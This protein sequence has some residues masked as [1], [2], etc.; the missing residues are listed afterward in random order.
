MT[1]DLA[2]TDLLNNSADAGLKIPVLAGGAGSIGPSVSTS[3]SVTNSQELSYTEYMLGEQYQPAEL[4]M[5]PPDTSKPSPIAELINAQ[6]AALVNAAIKSTHPKAQLCFTNFDPSDPTKPQSTVTIGLKFESD[7]QGGV[8]VD[9]AV[10]SFGASV[11]RKG[12]FANTMTV[13]YGSAA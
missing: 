9:L 1:V 7:N 6:R 8:K 10:L 3:R 11:G 12:S 5:Q 4:T 13:T 2:T